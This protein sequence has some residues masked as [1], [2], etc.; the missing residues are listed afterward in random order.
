MPDIKSAL[1][2]ASE[3]TSPNTTTDRVMIVN[4][5]GSSFKWISIATILGTVLTALKTAFTPASSSGPASLAFAE[6]TGNGTSKITVIGQ[7]ALAADRTLTLPDETGT[8]ATQAY[9]DALVAGLLD[10]KGSTDCSANP[11][12]PVASKGDAYIVSVAGKIGGASGKTVEV[13]DMFIAS[14][15]NA[16]GTEASVGTSWFVIQANLIGAMVGSNNL[17]EITNAGTARTNLGLG[18]VDNTSDAT[19]NAASA[20]LTNKKVSLTGSH[21]SNNTYDAAAQI[22]GKNAGATIAQWEAVYLDGSS[23]W[24]LADANGTNT[25]PARGLA[26]AAYSSSNAAIILKE[27]TVRN[28][29]WSWTPGGTIYL[30][31]TAGGLTQTQ[32]A[33]SGDKVQAVGYALDADR[34]YFDFNSFFFTVT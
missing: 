23:T 6:D 30:S 34:A 4:A 15:D 22:E 8:I 16:G 31:T 11:N 5:A 33:T 28:D 27:G 25:Y 2:A 32:P 3:E 20:T 18:N 13:G 21:G 14:A 19:K 26:V 9:A 17:S 7:S 29:S 1:A 10:L 12:Y 24:Q